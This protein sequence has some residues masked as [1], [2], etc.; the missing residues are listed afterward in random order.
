[1]TKEQ[2]FKHNWK[3]GDVMYQV[4]GI[5]IEEL[6]FSDLKNG[7]VPGNKLMIFSGKKNNYTII[8]NDALKIIGNFYLDDSFFS[9][10]SANKKVNKYKEWYILNVERELTE[11]DKEIKSLQERRIKLTEKL[12]QLYHA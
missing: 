9:I 12:N 4:D 7:K 8:V 3:F 1:M 11:I 2:F 6:T 10:S 5:E